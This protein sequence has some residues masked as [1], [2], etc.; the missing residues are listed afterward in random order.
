M[1]GAEVRTV[2]ELP[3]GAKLYLRR[4][5]REIEFAA[6]ARCI[7]LAERLVAGDIAVVK[8]LGPLDPIFREIQ[9]TCQWSDRELAAL[10]PAELL[11]LTSIKW[12]GIADDDGRTI[13]VPTRSDAVRLLRDPR[14][15][16]AVQ[17]TF[18]L[19]M[20]NYGSEP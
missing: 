5:T 18:G 19:E 4:L 20:L 3:H 2:V 8:E 10:F 16:E 12:E 1:S 17:F 9:K 11:I 13:E 7:E 14:V 15:M 6:R